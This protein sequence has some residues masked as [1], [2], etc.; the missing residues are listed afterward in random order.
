MADDRRTPPSGTAPE[1]RNPTGAGKVDIRRIKARISELSAFGRGDS[2]GVTRLALTEED[3]AARECF[4]GWMRGCGLEVRTDPAGNLIGRLQG[5]VGGLPA[6]ALGSH[7]DTVPEG[8]PLDGALGC[9]GALECA[10]ILSGTKGRLDHPLELIVFLD[11]EGSRFGTGLTGSRAVIGAVDGSELAAAADAEGISFAEAL[12]SFGLEPDRI[13]QA[14]RRASELAAYLELHVEQGGVLY[15]RGVAVG[16][17]I[18]I[19]G[20]KR[21]DVSVAGKANHA[22]TTPMSM[23]KDA[24]VSAARLI[25]AAGKRA[26][27]FAHAVAT[28][29]SIRA[30]PGSPNVIPGKV[31]LS[32][33]IRDLEE[34]VMDSLEEKL[35]EDLEVIAER[36]GVSFSVEQRAFIPPVALD[37]GVREI[38]RKVCRE[39]GVEYLSIPSGAGH[40]AGCMARLCPTG[41]IFVPSID[42]ISHNPLEQ[43]DWQDI[44]T[45][46]EVM[47]GTLCEI[48]ASL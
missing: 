44:E 11:E 38:I 5:R 6:I 14:V 29:G 15:N 13:R 37:P 41:M 24:L 45:G 20:I 26:A 36:D 17:V 10:E 48:D 22:G 23:R 28:I 19:V 2:G 8:G 9:V 21:F 18:G 27:Q 30:Y 7:L 43:T 42:G 47:Y 46:V 31:V 3:R 40:D 1:G 34:K 32:L 25:L 33:E 39:H 4:A 16:E 12:S 35:R